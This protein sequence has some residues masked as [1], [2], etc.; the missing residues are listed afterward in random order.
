MNQSNKE[1][2]LKNKQPLTNKSA[3][4]GV[5]SKFKS[6]NLNKTTEPSYES[7]SW[8]KATVDRLLGPIR[9]F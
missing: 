5:S 6:K 9:F 2:F 7:R 3:G 4:Q 8:I 1:I